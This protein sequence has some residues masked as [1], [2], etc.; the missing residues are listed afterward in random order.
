V[1][2]V[3]EFVLMLAVL[4]LPLLLGLLAGYLGRPWWWAALVAVALFLLAAIVPTPEPGESRVTGGDVSFLV[5]VAAL[6]AG[7]TWL[8]SLV[9]TALVGRSSGERRARARAARRA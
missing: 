3:A 2:L 7:A 8:G 5:I 1:D 4:G 6:V 9:G